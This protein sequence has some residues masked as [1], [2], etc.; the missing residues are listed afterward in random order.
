MVLKRMGGSVTKTRA[1][2]NLQA[3]KNSDSYEAKREAKTMRKR[4]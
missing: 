2:L 4:M 3:D 1:V